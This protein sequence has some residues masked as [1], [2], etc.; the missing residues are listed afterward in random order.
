MEMG[1]T[2]H[3]KKIL[4]TI[5]IAF[6]LFL[7]ASPAFATFGFYRT[8]TVDHTRVPNT[9]QTNFPVAVASST[10]TFLKTVG[11]G[12]KVQNAQGFDVGFYTSSDCSTGKM[13]WEQE[14]W[15]GSTGNVAYW[16]KNA[17]VSHTTDTVFYLCYGDSSITTDQ[18]A[19]TTVWD[20]NYRL[21]QHLANGTT[22]LTKDSSSFGLNA[23]QGVSTAATAG[24]IDG[25]SSNVGSLNQQISY[26]GGAFPTTWTTLTYAFWFKPTGTFGSFQTLFQNSNGATGIGLGVN[27]TSGQRE[28]DIYNRAVADNNFTNL[29][30][31][32][33]RMY[34]IVARRN[35]SIATTTLYDVAAGTSTTQT[36]TG[37]TFA[38]GNGNYSISTADSGASATVGVLDEVQISSIVRSDDWIT[39]EYNNQ[40]I[41][42]KTGDSTGFY[43]LGTE[44]PISGVTPLGSKVILFARWIINNARVIF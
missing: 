12:G 24:Q 9:D 38:N 7:P 4:S 5:A 43:T 11:N 17:T 20:T 31:A 29:K 16:I 1:T 3:M 14:S 15:N 18:S 6:A 10:Y 41:P 26:T 2:I 36:L 13:A 42:D 37:L 23:G 19:T 35:G 25:A 40:A 28:I 32:Q 39:T 30:L 27:D 44:T 33:N 8:V 34:Y 22:L 21:V